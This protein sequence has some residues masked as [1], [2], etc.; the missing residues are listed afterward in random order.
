MMQIVPVG[1]MVVT[2]ALRSGALV[3]VDARARQ[4][5][6]RP[7]LL[8]QLRPSASCAARDECSAMTRSRQR[9][10]V[11]A[12]V[13]DAELEEQVGPA[14]DAEAD[15]AVG[16]HASRRSVSSGYGFT[17]ITS[18]RKR[19]RRPDLVLELDPVDPLRR[20][21]RSSGDECRQVD[22][23]EVARLVRQERL[24]TALVDDEPIRDH[25]VALGLS[26]VV[27]LRTPLGSTATTTSLNFWV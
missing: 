18:S 12:V 14:H 25:R 7:A 26:E 19:T 4:F 6:K 8:G 16:L 15:A 23:A 24:L 22:R 21:G 1:A 3:L 17:S 11:L 9:S 5:G 10:G 27:D 2:V 20:L 13:G